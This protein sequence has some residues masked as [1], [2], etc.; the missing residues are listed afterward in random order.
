M[1]LLFPM[2]VREDEAGLVRRPP[3][4]G[5]EVKS[6]GPAPFFWFC[7]AALLAVLALMALAAAAPLARMA[8]SR[9]PLDAALA[10]AAVALL[11]AA[12]VLLVGLHGYA[13]VLVKKGRS[14][15][16]VHRIFGVPVLTRRLVL[17]DRPE[18]FLVAPSR[19]SPNMAAL[20]G[21]AAARAFRTQGHHELFAID[22]AGRRVRIDRH[23]RPADLRALAALLS[24]Y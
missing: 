1:G 21:D 12:P 4:G 22:E 19:P 3:G 17:A 16:V 2:P 6:H 7:L 5:V 23:T 15:A 8:S 13:K 18:P 9:D 24:K 14:L 20:R 10:R 11:G